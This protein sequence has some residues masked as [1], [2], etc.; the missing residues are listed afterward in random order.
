MKAVAPLLPEDNV[1]SLNKQ[2]E[3]V[4][5]IAPLSVANGDIG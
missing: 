4:V 5:A 2:E 1:L 3:G